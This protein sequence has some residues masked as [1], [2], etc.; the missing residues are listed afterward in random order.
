[1]ECHT[2]TSLIRYF[3]RV[4]KAILD[5]DQKTYGAAQLDCLTALSEIPKWQRNVEETAGNI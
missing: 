1:M 4:F 2:L 5:K 3:Y